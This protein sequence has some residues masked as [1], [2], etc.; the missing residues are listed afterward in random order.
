[1]VSTRKQ[2]SLDTDASVADPTTEVA[3]PPT[4]E[5]FVCCVCQDEFETP[6]WPDVVRLPCCHQL[7]HR[8]CLHKIERRRFPVALPCPLC[9]TTLEYSLNENEKW[10]VIK[11]WIQDAERAT[12]ISRKREILDRMKAALEYLSRHPVRSD[13]EILFSMHPSDIE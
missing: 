10:R 11:S 8:R 13:S 2:E 5:A 6:T 1:M 9:R 7:M 3:D 4:T 12:S